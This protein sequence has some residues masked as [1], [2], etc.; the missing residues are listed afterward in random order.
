MSTPVDLNHDS[1]SNFQYFTA[2][3]PTPKMVDHD[4]TKIQLQ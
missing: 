3:S 1:Q 4:I 2:G